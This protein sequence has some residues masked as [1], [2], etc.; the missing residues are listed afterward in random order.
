MKIVIS[1]WRAASQTNRRKWF[2]TTTYLLR[3]GSPPLAKNAT[4]QEKL[5]WCKKWH[6]TIKGRRDGRKRQG[7]WKQSKRGVNRVEEVLQTS[8]G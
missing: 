8:S 7:K 2:K 4:P 3:T 6:R 5:S 1:R